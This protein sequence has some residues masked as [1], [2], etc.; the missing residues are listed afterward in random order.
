MEQDSINTVKEQ[1]DRLR[2]RVFV[3]QGALLLVGAAILISFFVR[4]QKRTAHFDSIVTQQLIVQDAN[5]QDR[6]II[7]PVIAASA[8]RHRSD[9]LEGILILDENG[10]DRVALGATPT[11]QANGEVVHR[12]ENSVPYGLAFNDGQGNERGGFG[13]YDSRDYVSFGMDYSTGE[14]LNMFVAEQ[15]H[16]GQKV[17]LVMQSQEQGQVVYL[18]S[19][20]RQ[21][22]M[23]NLDVPQA[24]RIAFAIDSSG[25]AT[26]RHFDYVQDQRR[27]LLNSN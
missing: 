25:E 6:I 24:G 22:T 14:G 17:G 4:D 7:S 13:Y 2:K 10:T 18:G 1:V 9:T 23:L 12:W 27:L 16:Y 11:I 15:G 26:I 8:S 19:S 20:Q 21:E 3:L 5:G